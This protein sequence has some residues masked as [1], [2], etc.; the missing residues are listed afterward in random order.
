MKSLV[1]SPPDRPLT[2]TKI[3]RILVPISIDDDS[4]WGIRYALRRHAEGTRVEVILLNVGEPVSKG[5]AF[6]FV[7]QR[8]IAELQS[9]QAQAMISEAS[10]PLMLK[11]ISC[12][13]FF[14]QGD[15]AFSILDTAEQ[16][17]C[18]EIAMPVPKKGLPRYF[19]R[20]I[21]HNVRRRGSN[22]AVVVVSSEGAPLRWV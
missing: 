2:D 14:K 20:K 13:G 7:A 4:R 17:D 11:K 21:V 18:D 12:R 19:S 6:R 8:K 22:V 5:Q 10:K 1:S 15:V 16:L 9:G 3:L